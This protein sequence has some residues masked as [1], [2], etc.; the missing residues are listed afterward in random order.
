[1]SAAAPVGSEPGNTCLGAELLAVRG[2][3]FGALLEQ[4][5]VLAGDPVHGYE[6]LRVLPP[7]SRAGLVGALAEGVPEPAGGRA[8]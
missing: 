4:Q 1:M 2:D 3:T 7:G 6:V 8:A 5:A